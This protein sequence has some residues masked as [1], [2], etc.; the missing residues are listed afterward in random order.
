[1]AELIQLASPRGART[2][3]S[4]SA[5][6]ARMWTVRRF[7]C[8]KS[9]AVNS[10]PDSISPEMKWTLRA[11]RSNFAIMSVAPSPRH[12]LSAS[13]SFGA[14]GRV[15]APRN[16]ITL[17][18]LDVF[19]PVA[20]P[21][22]R[23]IFGPLIATR[24]PRSGRWCSACGAHGARARRRCQ[25]WLFALAPASVRRPHR[26]EPRLLTVCEVFHLRIVN[27]SL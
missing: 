23:S 26:R 10:T 4:C 17:R 9:T 14:A 24:S 7:A 11:S 13:A 21:A 1:V 2:R 22:G 27:R 12:A 25:S 19:C 6:A 16:R 20:A 3:A 8:G 5:T 18:R 15:G